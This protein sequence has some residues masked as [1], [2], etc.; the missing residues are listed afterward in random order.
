MLPGHAA[1]PP[2]RY[3]A[4][5]IPE[6]MPFAPPA[7]TAYSLRNPSLNRVNVGKGCSGSQ[8]HRVELGEA[9]PRR[10]A[11][12]P[13][14]CPPRRHPLWVNALWHPLQWAESWKRSSW[15]HPMS[16]RVTFY[17]D[18]RCRD[19]VRESDLPSRLSCLLPSSYSVASRWIRWASGQAALG[20]MCSMNWEQHPF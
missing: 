10:V 19:I 18:L 20:A 2:C 4:V 17:C 6:V 3:S 14:A 12:C 11:G 13:C 8:T 1:K 16:R 7:I 9:P 5:I 15:S